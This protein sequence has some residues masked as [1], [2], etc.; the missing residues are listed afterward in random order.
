METQEATVMGTG[1]DSELPGEQVDVSVANSQEIKS[2][3]QGPTLEQVVARQST[4]EENDDSGSS[5]RKRKAH[6]L[7]VQ[8]EEE[9]ATETGPSS[10]NAIRT[11]APEVIEVLD[12]ESVEDDLETQARMIV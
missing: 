12:D 6:G 3:G 8:S 9:E 10:N 7:S 11:V 5:N 2:E 4:S 1:A